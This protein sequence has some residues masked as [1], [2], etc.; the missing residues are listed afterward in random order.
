MR[1]NPE[2]DLRSGPP[3][4][5]WRQTSAYLM[6]GHHLERADQGRMVRL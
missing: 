5:P 4:W 1:Q 6:I 2:R 3:F